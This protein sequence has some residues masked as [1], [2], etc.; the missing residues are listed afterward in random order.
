MSGLMQKEYER[1]KLHATVMNTLFR[2][3]PSDSESPRLARGQRKTRESF[4][5]RSV[6]KHF[7]DYEF[8][9]LTIPNIHLSQRFSTGQDLYYQCVAMAAL[10][11]S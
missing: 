4:D 5:A 3:E 9:S 2:K 11:K 6:L 7:K 10:P 1:V 8:G